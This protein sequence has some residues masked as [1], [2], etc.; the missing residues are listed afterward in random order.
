[1]TSTIVNHNNGRVFAYVRCSAKDQN[2][3]RQMIAMEEAG[4]PSKNIF[5]E[6][7]SGK[8]FNR[9]VYQRLIK[10]LKPADVIV[11]KSID[12]LGRNYT[13]IQE[14]WRLITNV[15]DADIIVLDMP[16]LNTTNNEQDLTGKFISGLVLQILSYVAEVERENIHQRQM[17]GIAAARARG[18]RFGKEAMPL[19]DNFEEVRM[20]YL[21]KEISCRTAAKMLGVAHSTF[22]KWMKQKDEELL[23]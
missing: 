20:K 1:M 18:V 4:V 5:V 3:A 15:K 7:Q 14:Q 2:E 6:K 16:L 13:E 22:L 9:P 11:I 12:R 19:P 8:D 21:N 23:S 17:E 10:K